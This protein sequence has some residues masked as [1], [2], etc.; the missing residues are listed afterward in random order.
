MKILVYTDVQATEGA[1]RCRARPEVTL[2]RYRT[3]R[4]FI[5]LER[6]ARERRVDAVWDLGDT[7]DNRSEIPVP[8]IQ[9]VEAGLAWL[10]R[11]RGGPLCYKLIG[12]HEQHQK[13]AGV[14]TGALFNPFFRV[15]P[16]RE[17]FDW[18]RVEEDG[19]WIIAAAF[20]YDFEDAAAWIRAE[21]VRGREAN[22]NV[23]VIGHLPL[24]GA[25]LPGGPLATGLEADCL[26]G[27]DFAL[28]G[29][30][31]RHQEVRRSY[32]YVGSPFQQDFGEA[33]EPKGVALFDTRTLEV[34]FVDLGG[35]PQYRVAEA[36]GLPDELALGED[37]WKILVRDRAQAQAIYAR[38]WAPEVELTYLYEEAAARDPEANVLVGEPES[39]VKE[40]LA[41]HPAAGLD[42][43]RLLEM[44]MGFLRGQ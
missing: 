27:A 44:G 6:L 19:P 28:L 13:A 8:T 21:V 38:P 20:P 25:R 24:K 39:L 26:E 40:Y 34:E 14:H 42:G 43:A 23:I 33:G 3:A 9:V 5:E 22:R 17:V 12:N 15:V 29:H 11:G 4:F 10:M 1:E 30:V 37:R 36:A 41:T 16:E 2:Q 35:F 31:H 18:S 7:L 32:W